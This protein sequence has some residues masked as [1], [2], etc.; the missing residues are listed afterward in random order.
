M[1]QRVYQVY[2][3]RYEASLYLERI[4]PVLQIC[5]VA[6][7]YDKDCRQE[8]QNSYDFWLPID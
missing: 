1:R 6:K 3:H 2:Y 8:L 4:V 7:Y 5:K